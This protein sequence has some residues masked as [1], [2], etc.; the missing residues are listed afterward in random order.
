MKKYVLGVGAMLFGILISAFTSKPMT[1]YTLVFIGN[2]YVKSSVENEANYI[3]NGTHVGGFVCIPGED[4]DGACKLLN[5][6]PKYIHADEDGDQVLN[7][8]LPGVVSTGNPDAEEIIT[9]GTELDFTNWSYRI[10]EIHYSDANTRA[11]SSWEDYYMQNG[12]VLF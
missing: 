10:E 1:L 7:L 9:I 11:R 12:S 8:G 6:S 5:V 3:E 4:D 2:P